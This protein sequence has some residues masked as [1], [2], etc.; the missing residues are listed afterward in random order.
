MIRINHTTWVKEYKD[1]NFNV[2]IGYFPEDLMLSVVF[3]ETCYDIEEMADK[4]DSG[5][6][7]WFVTCVQY[8][9]EGIEMGSSYLNGCLHKD[10]CKAIEDGLDGY[11]EDMTCQAK[12]EA[13]DSLNT[14]Y[15]KMSHDLV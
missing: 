11:L 1:G 15:Q 14:L 6:L 9:Y 2:K 13:I 12:T 8:S 7:E 3:D 10:A 5:L 4:I